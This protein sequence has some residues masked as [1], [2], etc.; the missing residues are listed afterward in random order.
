MKINIF[1]RDSVMY[2]FRWFIVFTIGLAGLMS[3]ADHTGWRL[4]SNSQQ[5]Q[6]NA[7]GPGTHK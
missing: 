3:Y 1:N 4:L 5:Q 7:S 6:W 2:P